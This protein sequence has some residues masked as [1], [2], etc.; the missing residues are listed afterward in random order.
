M[1]RV[2]KYHPGP[3][4]PGKFIVNQSDYPLDHSAFSKA[5]SPGGELR[6]GLASLLG[7][8][9]CPDCGHDPHPEG[10]CGKW[11]TAPVSKH[12]TCGKKSG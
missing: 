3:S 2:P 1:S 12:C 9:R 10:E 7:L 8:P 4:E 5:F 11:L 6:R